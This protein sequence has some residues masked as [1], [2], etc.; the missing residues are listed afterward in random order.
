MNDP[1]TPMTRQTVIRKLGLAA[2]FAPVALVAACAQPEPP[3]PPV[4][5]A[6]PPPPPPPPPPAPAPVPRRR[7]RG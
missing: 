1:T 4:V 5:R 2:L 6:A 7:V 3:P